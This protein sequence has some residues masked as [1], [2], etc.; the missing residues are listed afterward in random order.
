MGL[1]MKG[2]QPDILGSPRDVIM[3]QFAMSEIVQES[4]KLMAGVAGSLGNGKAA[5]EILQD[6]ADGVFNTPQ[7]KQN[8]LTEMLKE[9][10]HYRHLEPE[11]RLVREGADSYLKVTGLEGLN[12]R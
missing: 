2:I 9:Y 12:G 5:K 1:F 4:R 10:E 8:R 11:A 6:F 3:R 7:T